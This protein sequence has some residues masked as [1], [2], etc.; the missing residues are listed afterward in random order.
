[1][2][3]PH[4]IGT[5]VRCWIS[6]IGLMS[7]TSVRAAQ[8]ARI[9]RRPSAIARARR[10]TSLATFGPA[11]GSPMSAVSIPSPSMRWRMS[12]FWS[13]VGDRTEGDCR[14]SRSVS[15]SSIAIGL[16]GPSGDAS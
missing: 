7:D 16:P 15:S 1:M 8:L 3:A 14:P 9:R 2:N 10:S 11:P 5:P 13:I 12:I 6:A 4:S